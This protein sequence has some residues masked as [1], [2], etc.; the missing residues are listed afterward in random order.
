MITAEIFAR[1][2]DGTVIENHK[3]YFR[4]VIY[5]KPI[6][7]ILNMANVDGLYWW[8]YDNIDEL[9]QKWEL[10]SPIFID[11]LCPFPMLVK[12]SDSTKDE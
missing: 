12:R 8:P 10:H 5:N 7:N 11:E 9:N 3:V 6:T 1:Q 2:L 4:S